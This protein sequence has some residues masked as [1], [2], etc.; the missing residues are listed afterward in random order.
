[1]ATLTNDDQALPVAPKSPVVAAGLIIA[2]VS[3]V[4][5]SLS[6]PL[7]RGL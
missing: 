5:F 3:A 4:T 6:G 1:M 7:G 2:V